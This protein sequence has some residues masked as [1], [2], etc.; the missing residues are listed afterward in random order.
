MNFVKYFFYLY[1][2]YHVIFSLSFV[3]IMCHIDW[4]ANID[5]F[6]HDSWNKSNLIMLYDPFI[7]CWIQYAS[8]SLRIFAFIFIKDID[9]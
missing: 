3:N 4:F 5:S 2:D 1:W 7:Y 6:L 9:L 8:N